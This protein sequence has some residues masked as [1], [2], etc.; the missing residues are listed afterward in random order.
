MTVA[1][2][3]NNEDHDDETTAADRQTLLAMQC[4]DH[5]IQVLEVK[6]SGTRKRFADALKDVTVE[7]NERIRAP[8]PVEVGCRGIL[9]DIQEL[10]QKRQKIESDKASGLESIKQ[11]IA[12]SRGTFYELLRRRANPLQTNLNFGAG[13]GANFDP[14]AGLLMSAAH[15]DVVRKAASMYAESAGDDATS[16][17]DEL[18]RRLD[19]ICEVGLE[20]PA[21]MEPDDDESDESDGDAEDGELNF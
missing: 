18:N 13:G 2:A 17:L 1:L 8:A 16:G 14:R 20:F 19:E 5:Q 9:I 10:D 3:K 7:L 12:E 4:L 6:M 11:Q 21:D 15:L